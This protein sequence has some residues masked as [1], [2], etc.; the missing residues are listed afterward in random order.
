[1]SNTLI[2]KEFQ[3]ENTDIETLE[4]L[5]YGLRATLT[6]KHGQNRI[7]AMF[8]DIDSGENLDQIMFFDDYFKALKAAKSFVLSVHPSTLGQESTW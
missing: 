6:R 4:C 1:M 2:H 5:Q 8:T 3:G 7:T